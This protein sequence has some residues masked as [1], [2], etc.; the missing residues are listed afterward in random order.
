MRRSVLTIILVFT[1][2]IN[3]SAQKHALTHDDL[4][5]IKRVSS[6]Q[7]SPDGKWVAYVVTVYDKPNNSGN[8]DIWLVSVDS[9][10]KR[11][12]TAS[13]NT[14]T[15]PKWS[16][17]GNQ[18]AF[19]STRDGSAQ[20]YLIPVSGGEARKISDVSTGAGGII[21]SPD[22]KYLAFSSE[23]YP[24][25]KNDEENRKHIEEKASSLVQAKIFD[26]LLYRQWNRWTNETR[27]HV[28]TI[29]V[30]GGTAKDVTPGDYDSPPLDLGGYQDYIVSPDGREIC[31]V[32]NTDPVVAVSTNNDL[33]ITDP[34]TGST[35]RITDNPANDNYP[36]YSPDGK[37]IAY[38]VMARAGFEADKYSLTLY[39]RQ[40]GVRT[41]I[42]GDLDRSVGEYIWAPDGSSIFFISNDLGYNSVYKADI[43][44]KKVTQI[45]KGRYIQGIHVT[46]DGRNLVFL[47][48]SMSE[49]ADIFKSDI[50]GGN[51]ERLTNTNAGLLSRIYMNDPEEFWFEGA[52][53][54]QVH[55]FLVKPPF[56]DENQKYPMVFLVHGG[57]QGAWGN[58]FHYRW[59]AQMFSAPGYVSVL[60]NPRGSTGYGQKFTD[61]ITGDWGGKVYTDLMN[62]LDYVLENYDFI[63]ED[64]LAAA[65]ASYGGY[66]MNWFE[67]HTDRFKCLVNHDGVFNLTSMYMHTEEL[68][69]PEWEFR[70]TPWDK[71]D[72]YKKWSPHNFVKNFNTPM[73]VIHSE[74]DYRVPVSEGFQVF[75]ALQKMNVPSKFLYFPD[76]DHWVHKP[77]NSELW[78][79]TIYDWIDEWINK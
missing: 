45:T 12:L 18:I 36:Q 58:M 65:G 11:Q 48:Q 15:N 34:V 23:V 68:W 56:F 53:G 4:F 49:P 63:D 44:S 74:L 50:S 1:L 16:P 72:M 14:D 47:Q 7:L 61:E 28:F 9:K 59:N 79:Q 73:L 20:I 39:D 52:G 5:N 77:L 31:Y 8:S 26:H 33:F 62:G 32:K 24:D 71:P 40:S 10:E 41:N 69:F 17:D 6:P 30:S 42:T 43:S 78:H 22:G 55:G 60:I 3:V 57:P 29:P 66:M 51:I 13:P 35:R 2:I 25:L 21:W 38:R 19:M 67:G 70:G 27:S 54:T 64:K 37:Y 46:P 75:T 76:E